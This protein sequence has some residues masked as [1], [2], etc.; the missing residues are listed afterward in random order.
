[1]TSLPWCQP[2]RQAGFGK[3]SLRTSV[4]Q[5][6]EGYGC[7]DAASDNSGEVL[8]DPKMPFVKYHRS[9]VASSIPLLMTC[10][11]VEEIWL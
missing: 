10:T 3:M 11:M 6:M 1:M 9:Q 8:P 5:P 2:F 4:C 7:G